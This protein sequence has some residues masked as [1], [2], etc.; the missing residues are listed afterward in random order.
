MKL[1]NKPF[2]FQNEPDVL[3]PVPHLHLR[4]LLALISLGEGGHW[5]LKRHLLLVISAFLYLEV[6]FRRR[7]RRHMRKIKITILK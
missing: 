1:T 3:S 6:Y 5:H 2:L 4:H 7:R